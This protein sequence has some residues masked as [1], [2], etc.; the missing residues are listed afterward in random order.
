MKIWYAFL[1]LVL[2]G[3]G[4]NPDSN[5]LTN[6]V[7]PAPKVVPTTNPEL[8]DPAIA[9]KP[10]NAP[11]LISEPAGAKAFEFPYDLSEPLKTYKMPEE[12]MEISGI[13]FEGEGIMA[14]VQDEKGNIYHYDLKEKK[15][16]KKSDFGKPGDYEGIALNEKRAFILRS[17]GKVLV[18]DRPFTKKMVHSD[19][20]PYL[21]PENDGEGLAIHPKTGKLWIACKGPHDQATTPGGRMVFELNPKQLDQS[22]KPVLEVKQTDIRDFIEAHQLREAHK[23]FDLFFSKKQGDQVFQTSDLAIHPETRNIYLISSALDKFLAVYSPS[24]RLLHFDHLSRK[25]FPQPEGLCFDDAG[26]LYIATE[27]KSEK[28][29]I[30]KF[31]AKN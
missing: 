5:T 13:D 4:P 24:G 25:T 26:N 27:G 29:K 23:S 8:V 10:E 31:N 9:K 20:G 22:P 2:W 3:C 6:E 14:C 7:D 1:V 17:D 21:I 11:D 12:L 16:V 28:G 15:I 19:F 18:V 30:V